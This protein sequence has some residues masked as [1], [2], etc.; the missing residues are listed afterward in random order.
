[1][2]E[3]AVAVAESTEE[4]SPG[5]LFTAQEFKSLKDGIEEAA[6]DDDAMPSTPEPAPEPVASKTPLEPDKTT[7][8]DEPSRKPEPTAD[9][10]ELKADSSTEPEVS[11]PAEPAEKKADE[12]LPASGFDDQLL[13][14][15]EQMGFS[16]QAAQS[17]GTPDKL[18][19]ALTV[20]DQRLI[21]LKKPTSATAPQVPAPQAP[22]Q[23]VSTTPP[24]AAPAQPVQAPP[25]QQVVDAL[26][27]DLDPD[28]HDPA[29]VEQFKKLHSHYEARANQF[30]QAFVGLFTAMQSGQRQSDLQA[31][32]QSIEK[33]NGDMKDLI[34][35]EIRAQIHPT[36][37]ALAGAL[38]QN[39][40]PVPSI[41]ELVTRAA[42]SLLSEQLIE[43]EHKRATDEISAK[44]DKRASQRTARPVQHHS[45]E[46]GLTREEKKDQ[47][48]KDIGAYMS[49]HGMR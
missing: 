25:V 30:E 32:N 9:S 29:I 26:T 27:I 47:D 45:S 20:L 36:A 11:E 19:T 44:L 7:P 22:A 16:K 21:G 31:V 42:R 2:S 33:L 13:A 38:S 8:A 17:F 43:K 35:P 49:E 23:Q 18:E 3:E 14:R 5:G 46:P 4:M 48:V 6:K 39:G 12:E 28:E 15:A 34:T 24:A 41:P 37:V 10:R 1:M 40:L